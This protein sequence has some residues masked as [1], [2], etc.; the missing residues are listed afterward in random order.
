MFL[1]FFFYDKF[2]DQRETIDLSNDVCRWTLPGFKDTTKS[3][4][5]STY[6]HAYEI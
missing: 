2:T 3:D 6:L 4:V 5:Y 1:F